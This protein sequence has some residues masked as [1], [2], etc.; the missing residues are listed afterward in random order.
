[1]QYD[2]PT[3]LKDHTNRVAKIENGLKLLER[4]HN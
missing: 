1:M 2:M 3:I 4:L